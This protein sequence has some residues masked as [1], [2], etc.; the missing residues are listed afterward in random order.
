MAYTYITECGG[1]GEVVLGGLCSSRS[2]RLTWFNKQDMKQVR[3]MTNGKKRMTLVSAVTLCAS[4]CLVF[5]IQSGVGGCMCV[6]RGGGI[7]GGGFGRRWEGD[8]VLPES[9][10]PPHTPFFFPVF[11]VVFSR[12]ICR[13][14]VRAAVEAPVRA[15][16]RVIRP[17]V[18]IRRVAHCLQGVDLRGGGVPLPPL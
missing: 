14:E 17:A 2:S 4:V 9:P 8:F 6:F 5:V 18:P 10:P 16:V 12:V 13:G 3:L 15:P 11:V 7:C 1:G